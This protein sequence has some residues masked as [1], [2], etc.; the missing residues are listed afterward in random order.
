[1]RH[2]PISLAKAQHRGI[3]E[4]GVRK[5]IKKGEV[6]ERKGERHGCLIGWTNAGVEGERKMGSSNSGWRGRYRCAVY[7]PVMTIIIWFYSPIN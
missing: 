4:Q 1:M 5:K 2:R 6:G 3:W 7:H